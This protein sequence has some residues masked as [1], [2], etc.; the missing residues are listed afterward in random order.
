MAMFDKKTSSKKGRCMKCKKQV[1]IKSPKRSKTKRGAIML[2][3]KCP[4]C[5]TTVCVFV[6]KE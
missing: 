3:G 4:K 1:T 5:S 2:K 6:K